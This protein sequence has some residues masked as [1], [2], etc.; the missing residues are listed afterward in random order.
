MLA[1]F[2]IDFIC[3]LP[4]KTSRKFNTTAR[5]I[6]GLFISSF[7]KNNAISSFLLG[8]L[9]KRVFCVFHIKREIVRNKSFINIL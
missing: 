4:K 2:S 5:A 7:D 9:E 8:F 1:I 6:S 3:G